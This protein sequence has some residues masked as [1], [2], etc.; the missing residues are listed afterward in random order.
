MWYTPAERNRFTGELIMRTIRVRK[1]IINE[2]TK[3]NVVVV[4]TYLTKE[5]AVLHTM[6]GNNV[7]AVTEIAEIRKEVE[8]TIGN[9]EMMTNESW[10][11]RPRMKRTTIGRGVTRIIT[12][13]TGGIVIARGIDAGIATGNEIAGIPETTGQRIVTETSV[14]VITRRRIVRGRDRDREIAHHQRLER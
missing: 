2:A 6:T 3:A 5:V 1:T 14:R 8:T 7:T 4:V 9:H 10:S 13:T 12:G 11:D